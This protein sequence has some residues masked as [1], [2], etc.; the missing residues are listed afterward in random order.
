MPELEQTSPMSRLA[1]LTY[2]DMLQK[3]QTKEL[4]DYEG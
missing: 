4:D 3:I 2:E 1:Y